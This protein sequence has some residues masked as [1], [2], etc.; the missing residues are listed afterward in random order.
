M[1]KMR[2]FVPKLKKEPIFYGMAHRFTGI[3][4]RKWPLWIRFLLFFKRDR[5][6]FDGNFY[7]RSKILFGKAYILAAGEWTYT[8]RWWRWDKY[9]KNRYKKI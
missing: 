6:G 1:R 8:R 4:P 2:N 5:W 3:M 9:L 7:V